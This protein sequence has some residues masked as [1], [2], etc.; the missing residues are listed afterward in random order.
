MSPRRY[1]SVDDIVLRGG[2]GV[3]RLQEPPEASA[4]S[5]AVV[6]PPAKPKR[7]RR[8]DATGKKSTSIRTSE[9]ELEEWQEAAAAAG[10]SF[11]GWLRRSLAEAVA[12]ERANT[13]H[14]EGAPASR[15]T[16]S[17]ENL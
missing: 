11:N 3:S 15:S 16:P 9:T 2:M 7:F 14:P 13:Q 5:P 17:W 10:E 4:A 12:L 8:P 6:E 1:L